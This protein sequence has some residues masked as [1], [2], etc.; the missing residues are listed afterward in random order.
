[1]VYTSGPPSEGGT[2]DRSGTGSERCTAAGDPPPR[3][4]GHRQRLQ[5][6]PVLRHHAAGLLHVAPPLRG[7]GRGGAARPVTQTPREP[8]CDED[9]GG[10]Q[11]R[12]PPPEL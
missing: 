12:L 5:D 3:P 9:R 4:G 1:M 6:L 7:A 10:R 2:D 11:D 8:E